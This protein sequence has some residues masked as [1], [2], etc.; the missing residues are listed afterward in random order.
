MNVYVHEFKMNYRSVI[1]W[2]IALVALIFVYMSVFPSFA[3]QA[4]FLD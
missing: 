4:E 3:S 2:S 1:Y